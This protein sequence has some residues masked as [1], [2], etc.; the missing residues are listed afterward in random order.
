MLN[1]L[2]SALISGIASALIDALASGQSLANPL[3]WKA[4]GITAIIAAIQHV[5]QTPFPGGRR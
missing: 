1:F 5:R 2:L 3:T 4:A